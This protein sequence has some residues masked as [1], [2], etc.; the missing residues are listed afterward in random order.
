MQSVQEVLRPTLTLSDPEQSHF[1][2][3]IIS[4]EAD[5]WSPHDITTACLLAKALSRLEKINEQL[6]R[7][8]E[9]LVNAKGTQIAHPLLSASMNQANSI[10]ALTR[11]LGLSA[12]QRGLSGSE[13]ATRN[14]ADKTARDAIKKAQ[15]DSLLA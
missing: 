13:Q 1:D 4:R 15:E 10:Q 5:S 8:G 3:I 9:M 7:D 2:R 12:S 11:T 14:K 6:D